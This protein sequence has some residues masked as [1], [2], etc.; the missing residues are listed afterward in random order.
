MKSWKRIAMF[1]VVL[2]A[3]A[4]GATVA[5][6]TTGAQEAAAVPCCDAG[7][8]WGY[9]RCVATCESRGGEDC[10]LTCFDKYL[11][12]YSNCESSC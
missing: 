12:C 4:S 3:L 10:D 8:D 11:P 5:A 2:G 6:V 1:T 7:C 9:N